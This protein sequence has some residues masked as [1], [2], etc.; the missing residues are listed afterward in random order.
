MI[1]KSLIIVSLLTVTA[2]EELVIE[3]NIIGVKSLINGKQHPLLQKEAEAHAAYQAKVKRQGHQG[4]AFRVSR[5]RSAIADCTSFEE[6]A[7]ESWPSQNQ[8][9]AAKEMYKSWKQSKGHWAIVNGGC[10]YYG[11]AMVKGDNGVW[12]ACFIVGR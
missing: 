3:G 2:N 11:C 12:Y 10:K 1:L 8:N 7:N 6:V 4:W 9:A 5:I